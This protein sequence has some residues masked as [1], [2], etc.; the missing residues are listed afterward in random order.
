MADGA[1]DSA[2]R[3]SST[4][5]FSILVRNTN[6]RVV[7]MFLTEKEVE[8]LNH[9]VPVDAKKRFLLAM[10][11][12]SDYS[13]RNCSLERECFVVSKHSFCSSLGTDE[14]TVH[15]LFEAVVK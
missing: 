2:P 1:M 12:G 3:T 9:D 5:G 10:A 7:R 14:Y 15:K 8:C 13:C 6:G 4:H 11:K